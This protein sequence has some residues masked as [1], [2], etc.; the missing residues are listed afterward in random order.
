MNCA[1]LDDCTGSV[2]FSDPSMDAESALPMGSV[3]APT[4]RRGHAR[5]SP[6]RDHVSPRVAVGKQR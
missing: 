6:R 5:S 3:L 4:R 2:G 1:A